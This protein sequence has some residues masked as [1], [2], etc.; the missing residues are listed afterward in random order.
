[1]GQLF[2]I[3]EPAKLE[4]HKAAA[5]DRAREKR[6]TLPATGGT[7]GGTGGGR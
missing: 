1:M 4:R 7:P 5:R 3:W 6:L 2:Q